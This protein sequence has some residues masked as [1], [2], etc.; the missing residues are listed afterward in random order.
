MS[1]SF[2]KWIYVFQSC[3]QHMRPTWMDAN[4]EIE[5]MGWEALFVMMDRKRNGPIGNLILDLRT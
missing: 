3:E 4:K 1:M 2:A 5:G